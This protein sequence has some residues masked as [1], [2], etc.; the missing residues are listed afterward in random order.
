[1]G[2]EPIIAHV[3][4]LRDISTEIRRC[5]AFD[6]R[7]AEHREHLM[8]RLALKRALIDLVDGISTHQQRAGDPDYDAQRGREAANSI[9][10]RTLDASKSLC[11]EDDVQV[12]EL[13]TRAMDLVMAL[14]AD[15]EGDPKDRENR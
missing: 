11:A 4:Q 14:L 1:M 3:G 10:L 12:R 15:L 2:T 5:P 7:A 6:V 13:A 8:R 9:A